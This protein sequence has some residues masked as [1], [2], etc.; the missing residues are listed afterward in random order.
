MSVL[1]DPYLKE[2]LITYIGN[3]RRL[4]PLIYEALKQGRSAQGSD[5]F[6]DMF[7]GSGVV[8]RLAR[9][10]GFSVCSNDWEEYSRILGMSH[11]TLSQSDIPRLFGSR[12]ALKDLLREI[13]SLSV[14]HEEDRY[15][16]LY[17]SP[18]SSDIAMADYRV[19]RLFYTRENALRI[20]AIR[21]YIEQ[22]Y[23][24]GST[25]ADLEIRNLL[26]GLLLGECSK[27]TNT[28]GVFKAFHKGFGGH[29]QDALTRIL[30]KIELPWPVLPAH[31]APARVFCQDAN[32]L[33]A[34]GEIPEGGI[35]YLDPPYNQHQY[36]SNYHML[37]T[38]ALW[39]KIPAPMVLNEK[40]VL[41]EKAA[42]RKDWVKTRSSYCYRSKAEE[43]FAGLMKSIRSDKILISYSNDGVIPFERMMD[44]CDEKGKTGILSNEYTKY[45]GG[46]QSNHRL[47]S[48]I[49]YVMT[50][51][52]G[53][54]STAYS[55]NKVRRVLLRRELALME[56]KI[57][58]PDLLASEIG[59][60]T[61]G[62]LE[63]D[64]SGYPLRL[65]L[66]DFMY[67]TIESDLEQ[68]KS[69]ALRMLLKKLDA[70]SCSSRV[71][72]L[73]HIFYIIETKGV[74]AVKIR[75][76]L[77]RRVRM[78]AHKKTEKEYRAALERISLLEADH[79]LSSITRELDQI[80]IQA[81]KRFTQ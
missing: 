55:R 44:I 4:L 10:M 80:R 36:G 35:T 43:A 53:A 45:R 6:V 3:K 56:K 37:N 38:I 48:N 33:A 72:E 9:L 73:D 1:S 25:G 39:D 34:S 76:E 66:K 51:E 24:P 47:H 46:R 32:I 75:R 7:S 5:V 17:Y 74:S 27:H 23:P 19:E 65:R 79:D 16:S 21:S 69:A 58:R 26:I 71:E 64:I 67:L 2:Q 15:I 42:I 41:R 12:D 59:D 11:L 30:K 18:S 70:S 68:W 77:P 60:F 57:F 8:S 52:V 14:P 13:N 50:V 61:E 22:N 54:S 28:S 20:D 78:L 62:V 63:T 49:E 31:A 29:G 40:G 81:E